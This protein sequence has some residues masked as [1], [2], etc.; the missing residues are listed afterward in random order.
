[1]SIQM[2]PL[3]WRIGDTQSNGR[4]ALSLL[5]PHHLGSRTA[6]ELPINLSFQA[7][8]EHAGP[9]DLRWSE[10]DVELFMALLQQKRQGHQ[11]DDALHGMIVQIQ[12]D[13]TFE[14][15]LARFQTA[16][17][18]DAELAEDLN[19]VREE[20][21]VGALVAVN[22]GQSFPLAVV[23][24]L[25]SIEAQC[26]LLEPLVTRTQTLADGSLVMLS[27]LA[28]LPAHFAQSSQGSD[29]TKH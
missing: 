9:K 21:E 19:T 20:L 25:D 7:S 3:F 11:L 8:L 4:G 17:N 18:V 6:T 27:R 12:F 14:L 15:V 16:V 28:A 1:M 10:S 22:D 29:T 5:M 23:V 2:Q 26:I 13:L 24:M